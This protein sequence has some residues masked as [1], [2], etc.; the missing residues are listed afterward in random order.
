MTRSHDVS[1][2]TALKLTG[3]AAAATTLAGCGSSDGDDDSSGDNNDDSGGGAVE[4]EPGN[5]ILFKGMTTHWEGKS[6]SGIEG[7]ENPTIALTEGET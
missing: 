6:P 1:R 7:E 2:R 3:A 4:I 5:E